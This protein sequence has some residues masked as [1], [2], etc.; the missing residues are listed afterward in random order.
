MCFVSRDASVNGEPKYL[1]SSLFH[2]GLLILYETF[3]C[4]FPLIIIIESQE[5]LSS[6]KVCF[7][8]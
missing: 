5:Q 3:D 4:D 1:V 6:V 2:V 7:K 8:T